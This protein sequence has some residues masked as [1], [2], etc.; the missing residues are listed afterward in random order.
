MQS[1]VN[2]CFIAIF[3][4]ALSVDMAGSS[5]AN[6]AALSQSDEGMPRV[7]IGQRQFVTLQTHVAKLKDDAYALVDRIETLERYFK[8]VYDTTIGGKELTPG[9]SDPVSI[10]GEKQES[11]QKAKGKG[12]Q[13]D[14]K[15][16]R[17]KPPRDHVKF[18][19][20]KENP[21]RSSPYSFFSRGYAPVV[22]L[23]ID[24]Y[25]TQSDMR[26]SV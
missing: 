24:S 26:G 1:A 10:L 13:K 7:T 16:L 5:T 6:W 18:E 20:T 21:L 3:F 2:I 19:A 15:G 23:H 8:A 25:D 12:E 14:E 11:E 4:F 22:D 9:V 17:G